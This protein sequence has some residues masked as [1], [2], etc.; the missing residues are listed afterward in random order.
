MIK[1]AL[2]LLAVS[3]MLAA[4]GIGSAAEMIIYDAGERTA[5][6]KFAFEDVAIGDANTTA[7]W[8]KVEA[9]NDYEGD[10]WAIPVYSNGTAIAICGV[11]NG[12]NYAVIANEYIDAADKILICREVVFP[13]NF[14]VIGETK[15]AHG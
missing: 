3:V 8:W 11:C 4:I 15:I 7:Q 6:A 2:Y 9:V 10:L 14:I 1:I 13:V 12:Y 5:V